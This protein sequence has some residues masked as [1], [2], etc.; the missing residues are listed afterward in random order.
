[1]TAR[2]G[3]GFHASFP[4]PEIGQSSPRLGANSVLNCTE[5]LQKKEKYSLEKTEFDTK[6]HR[7]PAE[8]GRIS[9]G[10]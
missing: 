5:N 10:E 2:D 9:T 8:T 4:R 7:E 6:L 1:M 3:M